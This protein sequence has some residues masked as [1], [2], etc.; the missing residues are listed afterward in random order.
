VKLISL[1]GLVLIFAVG[2]RLSFAA[3]VQGIQ[4][5]PVTFVLV[6]SALNPVRT[7]IAALT[8]TQQARAANG[9]Y[10]VYL[11]IILTDK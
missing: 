10:G 6:T 2:L 11:P 1:V 7:A 4:S 9:L 3:A 5:D 8:Q